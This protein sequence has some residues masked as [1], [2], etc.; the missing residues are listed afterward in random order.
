MDGDPG[1]RTGAAVLGIFQSTPPVWAETSYNDIFPVVV[2]ISIHSA[3]VGGDSAAFWVFDS[4]HEISIHSAR[5]GGD[6]A[7]R[8]YYSTQGIS[9]HSARV[10][11]DVIS[12]SFVLFSLHFNPLRPCGRRPFDFALNDI[13]PEF[14]STPPVWAETVQN[15]YLRISN[16]ISIHSAR[17]GGDARNH[18]NP[19]P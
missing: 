10:G 1:R 4:S 13:C 16:L 11:G 7:G 5:V 8:S 17:V 2:L 3:R 6:D 18:I 14:Q 19:P 15:A 9:I 12:L